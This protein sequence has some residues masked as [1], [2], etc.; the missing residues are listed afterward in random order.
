MKGTFQ[1]P[2]FREKLGNPKKRMLE[3]EY[4]IRF[5]KHSSST[6]SSISVPASSEFLSEV[7]END[8]RLAV[9]LQDEL[10]TKDFMENEFMPFSRANDNELPVGMYGPGHSWNLPLFEKSTMSYNDLQ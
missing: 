6:A 3:E 7:E 8:F 10:N 5:P 4:A 2:Y 1:R 9:Q